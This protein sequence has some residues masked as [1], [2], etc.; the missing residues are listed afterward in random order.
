MTK[1]KTLYGL[2]VFS[3]IFVITAGVYYDS[4][5]D[6][7]PLNSH[8][9]RQTDCLSMVQNYSEGGAFCMTEMHCQLADN[10]TSG[11]SIGEFPLLYYSVGHI[12]KAFGKSYIS[13]RIFCLI[14]LFGG[15][16]A[17]FRSLQLIFRE[18]YWSLALALL[19][20]TS[21]VFAVYGV[22]FLTDAPAFSFILMAIYFFTLY[23]IRKKP[24]GFY[25]C[26]FFFIIGGLSKISML[27]AFVVLGIVLLLE[28]VTKLKTLGD[29][30]LF[31]EKWRAWI[32]FSI[33]PIVIFSWYAY[34]AHF[35]GIHGFKYTFNHI[36]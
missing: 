19:L 26:I 2:I 28:T 20:F 9:W 14:I 33:V 7:G 16:L 34:A 24:W 18:N 22:G 1:K 13:Y 17:F 8:L 6:K 15:M 23:Q 12:W 31:E 35:N 36:I 10:Y 5:L 25:L 3:L 30:Q 29:R 27:T 11:Y 4:V 32:G 21:P